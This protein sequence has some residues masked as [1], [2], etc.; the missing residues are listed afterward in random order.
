[1]RLVQCFMGIV[2]ALTSNS[3]TLRLISTISIQ[4]FWTPKSPTSR[5][6]VLRVVGAGTSFGSA[7]LRNQ[8]CESYH[9]NFDAEYPDLNQSNNYL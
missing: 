6:V 4:V 8:K 2:S 9:V 5:L 7:S 1:M 3:H